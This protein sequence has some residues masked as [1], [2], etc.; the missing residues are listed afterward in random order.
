M[1]CLLCGS[2]KQ[3][4]F[5]V[6]E[7]FG[8]PLTYYQC[9]NCGFIFQSLEESPA[10]EV[11]FYTETYRMLYQNNEEPTEKDL[12]TQRQRAVYLLNLVHSLKR[13]NPQRI[14]D[15][16]ASSGVFIRVCQEI[17]DADVIGVQPG[18]AYRAYAQAKGLRMYASLE[19]LL[20]TNPEK[21]DLVSMIHVLEH[22][23]SPL[24]T[25]KTI[26]EKL[27]SERG[28]LLLEVPN[29]YAHDSYELAH[30]SCFTPHTLKE[31]V[32]QAGFK[33]VM[34]SR[35]GR[36]R[37]RLLNLYLK[38]LARPITKGSGAASVKPE[39]YVR[40]KRKAGF[41]YRRVVQ[42]LFPHQAWLPLPGEELF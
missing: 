34:L 40:M 5:E 39:R 9:Q 37:S 26:R 4:P 29:F 14:L 20:E 16:G 7:S 13:F 27:I 32:N 17:F 19:T 22:L 10:A 21:F 30:L 15:I 8:I 25:L 31:I 33:V 41:F 24:E 38:V 18:D 6:L 23:P 28:V 36:P 11:D 35:Y 3:M 1:K 42:K 2:E 12:W